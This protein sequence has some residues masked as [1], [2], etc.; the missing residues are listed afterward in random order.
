MEHEVST[1]KL[2]RSTQQVVYYTSFYKKTVNSC[3]VKTQ[4]VKMSADSVLCTLIIKLYII[5]G[6]II[7]VQIVLIPI[8]VHPL[9]S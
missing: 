2:L 6:H 8:P 1:G 9:V 3:H 5:I 4:S 7:L